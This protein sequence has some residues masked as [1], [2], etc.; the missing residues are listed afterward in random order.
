MARP[1]PFAVAAL[2][3]AL[4]WR[5]E[6]FQAWAFP[7]AY[8]E[9]EVQRLTDSIA[10]ARAA[11]RDAQDELTRL[12]ADAST[13]EDAG[14]YLTLRRGLEEDITANEELIALYRADLKRLPQFRRDH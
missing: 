5:T 12:R 6:R 2:L 11:I 13:P 14:V 3:V 10:M 9:A 8:H 7:E 4:A 1:L